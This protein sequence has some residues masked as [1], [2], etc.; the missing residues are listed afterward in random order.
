MP[1]IG[2]VKFN[3]DPK[4]GETKRYIEIFTKEPI[5]VKSGDKLYLNDFK[6]ETD[7]LLKTG[8]IDQAQAAKRA[9]LLE[10][11]SHNVNF[12]PKTEG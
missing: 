10:F 11:I 8:K 12:V 3:K 6:A 5:T 9:S 1:S 2:K 4:T 7:F